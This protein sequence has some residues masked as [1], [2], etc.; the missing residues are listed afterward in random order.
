MDSR[1]FERSAKLPDRFVGHATCSYRR[2]PV[3]AEVLI[4]L[5]EDV[6]DGLDRVPMKHFSALEL[7]GVRSGALQPQ[8]IVELTRHGVCQAHQID[9]IVAAK[10]RNVRTRS[11]D[12]SNGSGKGHEWGT[13]PGTCRRSQCDIAISKA[14]I[15]PHVSKLQ[16]TRTSQHRQKES[17]VSR[18]IIGK[19]S[20]RTASGHDLELARSIVKES[21]RN[22]IHAEQLVNDVQEALCSS[23]QSQLAPNALRCTKENFGH[24]A[25]PRALSI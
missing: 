5:P 11:E 21:Q 1:L 17:F 9:L 25:L 15:G 24:G 18:A 7:I 14:G 23:R 20:K 19:D 22:R 10:G 16:G 12:Y 2:D 3:E 8:R 13:D 4:L 6:R